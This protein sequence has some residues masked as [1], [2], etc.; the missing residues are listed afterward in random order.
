MPDI[1][2]RE[3]APVS[4]QAWEQFDKE[5]ARV[6]RQHL[7]GRSVVDF[8]GPHGWE[9]GAVNLGRLKSTDNK[10]PEGVG[11]GTREN[12]S[13]I[14]I[15]V[16]FA[17]RQMEVDNVLRGCADADFSPLQEA[18]VKAARFEDAAIFTGFTKAG[19]QGILPSAAHE[20]VPLPPKASGYP[21]AVGEAL[22]LLAAAGIGGPYCLVLPAEQY[23]LLMKAAEGGYPP[24]R[25]VKEMVQG[26][27]LPSMVLHSGVLVSTR[28][29][30]FEL[31]VGVD[32]AMGYSGS[33]GD[34]VRL[35]VTES[36]TFRVLEPNAAVEFKLPA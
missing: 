7:V 20:A 15:R 12:L 31:T 24:H 13:L 36:F 25:V 35:F 18:A 4:D 30:D 19:I 21:A 9:L 11:W 2:R 14:E 26:D 32:L 10:T 28:G 34:S 3:L 29:G 33:D 6:L 23:G 8:S 22:K 17:L 1:L 16:P 5:A 27:V